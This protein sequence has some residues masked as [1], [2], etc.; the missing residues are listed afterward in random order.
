MCSI[1]LVIRMISYTDQRVFS[2]EHGRPVLLRTQ[3]IPLDHNR[4]RRKKLSS[5]LESIDV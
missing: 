2:E 4:V 3:T 5:Y 1:L